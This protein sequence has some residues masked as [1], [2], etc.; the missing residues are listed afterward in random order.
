MFRNI[1]R[2]IRVSCCTLAVALVAAGGGW[3]SAV[4]QEQRL[5][6]EMLNS[7]KSKNALCVVL[8]SEDGQLTVELSRGGKFLVHGLCTQDKA[9]ARARTAIAQAQ[10]RGIVSAE[11]GSMA[12]L[13]YSDNIVNLVV[14]EN[15]R[16][17]VQNGL[18]VKQVLR[19]LRPGGVAWLG[20]RASGKDALS[21]RGLKELLVKAGI[22]MP[23]VIERHGVWAR[24]VKPRPASMGD[25]THKRGSASGNPVSTDRQIGVPTGVRWVA[26][27]NWP[28]GHRKSA[29]PAVVV[30]K[31]YLVY[32][33][34]DEV[35]SAKS[36]QREN[37]L[38]VRDAY[39]GLRLWRRKSDSLDIVALADRIYT[40]I[41]GKLV[42]LDGETGKVARTFNVE[43]PR[44][45]LISNGLLVVAGHQGIKALDPASGNSRWSVPLVPKKMRAGGGR[46]FL[47]VDRSRRGGDSQLVCL[48]LKTG[49]Q[50]WAASTKLWA[51]KGS[52]DLILY[53]E[54]VLVAA[55]SR[56]NHA[57]SATDGSH[58]WDYTYP[59]IGHGGSFAKVMAARGLIWVHTANSQGS[60]Q[61]AWEGLD[62]QTGKMKKR[63]LQPKSYRYKHRCS[64]DVGTGRG[65]LAFEA[66]A[67]WPE[68]RV[69]GTDPS[70]DSC[71][72][73]QPDDA[74]P[75]G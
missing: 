35:A 53:G 39:N 22:K 50:Q 66:L 47:H 11:T 41:G 28:T 33:F 65:V 45:F 4:A 68:T 49:K 61:Y 48:D 67:R 36:A 9:V 15:F 57:V 73:P 37:S 55:S 56:G 1:L 62:P 60:G 44:E 14:A 52:F 25:W 54:G 58:L 38:I 74:P 31:K 24:V 10:L 8:G 3:Q 42:A 20:S 72:Q 29:V 12:R 32:V 46:L 40:K 64:S 5:A 59:R 34:Q 70:N 26:G 21:A 16:G 17:L 75:D 23:V 63:L 71:G 51:K 69:I 30:S 27:P 7:V 19:V 6:E 43:G 13:P 2:G 18:T